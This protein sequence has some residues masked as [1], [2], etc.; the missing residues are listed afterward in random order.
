MDK[1]NEILDIATLRAQTPS[2]QLEMGECFPN[3][4]E[5][6]SQTKLNT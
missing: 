1:S 2:V 4:L 6:S 5:I 3:L